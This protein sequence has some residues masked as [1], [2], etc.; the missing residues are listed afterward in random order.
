MMI[1]IELAAFEYTRAMHLMTVGSLK[2]WER[3][4]CKFPILYHP[5]ER[6]KDQ[7]NNTPHR[8][9]GNSCSQ[10]GLRQKAL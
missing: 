9:L 10:I 4:L 8:V 6:P 5:S 3:M 1:G 7:Q 2:S